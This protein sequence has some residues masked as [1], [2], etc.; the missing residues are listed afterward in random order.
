VRISPEEQGEYEEVLEEDSRIPRH[1]RAHKKNV[2]GLKPGQYEPAQKDTR[3]MRV[4]GEAWL[5]QKVEGDMAKEYEKLTL[6]TY[7]PMTLDM[8]NEIETLTGTPYTLRD[9]NLLMA[10]AT[11]DVTARPYTRHSYVTIC[12]EDTRNSKLIQAVSAYIGRSRNQSMSVNDSRK[13]WLKCTH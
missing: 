10:Q 6:R 4:G 8:A 11:H 12:D 7:T 2:L 1:D 13:L 5:Q 3:L 9:E